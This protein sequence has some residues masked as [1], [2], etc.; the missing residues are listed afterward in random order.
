MFQNLVEVLLDIHLELDYSF[1]LL[2]S[3]I[4]MIYH[5]SRF[6]R[7]PGFIILQEKGATH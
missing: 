6:F 7:S 4:L 2:C 5:K 1:Y 3:C